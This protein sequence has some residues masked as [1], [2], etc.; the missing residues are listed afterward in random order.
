[1]NEG[2]NRILNGAVGI[3]GTILATVTPER[4]AI[5]AGLATGFWMLW[6]VG[7]SVWDRVKT[8]RE[9]DSQN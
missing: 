8:R 6:Q 4:A 2:Q 3:G 1:M 7:L 9:R 5:F